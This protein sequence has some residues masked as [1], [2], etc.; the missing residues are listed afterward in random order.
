MIRTYRELRRIKSFEER[1][2]YLRLSGTIGV[3]T[4][5]YDRYL[6]QILYGT[7]EWSRARDEVIVRD[8][9]ND[10]GIEGYE[11]KSGIWVH[12]MNPLTVE[13]IESGS[14]DIFDPEYLICTSRLTHSAIHYGD[15]SMLPK[16]PIERRPNDTCPWR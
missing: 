3:A 15:R 8:G 1:Y 11:L 9:G 10:L 16:L 5:G 6:N 14:K 2:D 7:E 13:D 4:F 12:H